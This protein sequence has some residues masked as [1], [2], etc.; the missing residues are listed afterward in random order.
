MKH[1][2]FISLLTV[3][4][5]LVLTGCKVTTPSNYNALGNWQAGE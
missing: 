2:F 3:A 4:F 1:K 5:M